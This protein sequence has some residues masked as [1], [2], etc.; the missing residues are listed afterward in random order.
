MIRF[1][2]NLEYVFYIMAFIS[3]SMKFQQSGEGYWLYVPS[4]MVRLNNWEKGDIFFP[5]PEANCVM[6]VY[7][8]K[9]KK[10]VQA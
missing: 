5:V 2:F 6:F 1:E 9:D 3:P 4:T 8:C 10:E 7:P